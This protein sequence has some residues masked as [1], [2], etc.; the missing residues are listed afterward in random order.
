MPIEFVNHFNFIKFIRNN[1]LKLNYSNVYNLIYMN[2]P[3]HF[4]NDM[5]NCITKLLLFASD[6]IRCSLLF[7]KC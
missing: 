2:P 6:K 4:F 7:L 3:I 5:L 1:R